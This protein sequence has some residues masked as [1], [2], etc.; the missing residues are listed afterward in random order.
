MRQE[1]FGPTVRRVPPIADRSARYQARKKLSQYLAAGCRLV[2][3]AD[4]PRRQVEVHRP[5]CETRILREADV[6]DGEDVLP[7]FR[8]RVADLFQLPPGVAAPPVG[9]PTANP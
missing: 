3:Y 6:L 7:G 4:I 8:C 9:A 2:W 5:G 1:S